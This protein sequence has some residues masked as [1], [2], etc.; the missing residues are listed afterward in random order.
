M[1]CLCRYVDGIKREGTFLERI[2]S[3]FQ[4]PRRNSK[5]FK[6]LTYFEGFWNRS[7]IIDFSDVYGYDIKFSSPAQFQKNSKGHFHANCCRIIKFFK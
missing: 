4:K 1:S 7:T 2:F 3:V 6:F 5:V